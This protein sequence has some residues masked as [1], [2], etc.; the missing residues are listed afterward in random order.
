MGW[1]TCDWRLR[2]RTASQSLRSCTVVQ[3]SSR[4]EGYV[5]AQRHLAGFKRLVPVQEFCSTKFS[6]CQLQLLNTEKE[7]DASGASVL[8]RSEDTAFVRDCDTRA[9]MSTE[10]GRSA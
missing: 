5:L 1:R 10:Y 3:L 2:S 7:L 4:D 6:S 9:R 8:V